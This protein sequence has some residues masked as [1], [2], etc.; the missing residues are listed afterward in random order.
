MSILTYSTHLRD[1]YECEHYIKNLNKIP[2]IMKDTILAK[3]KKDTM[4]C[5]GYVNIPTAV[6]HEMILHILQFQAGDRYN[7]HFTNMAEMYNVHLISYDKSKKQLIIWSDEDEE[8][9]NNVIK[10]I[11]FMFTKQNVSFMNNDRNFMRS[12][13]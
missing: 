7:T 2:K 9:I 11:K 1:S 13:N 5:Y 10:W 12:T 8:K 4:V 3:V 6:S